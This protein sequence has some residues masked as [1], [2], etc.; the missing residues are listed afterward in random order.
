MHKRR[1]TPAIRLGAC[2]VFD[3]LSSSVVA[4]GAINT[5]E[6]RTRHEG[7]S[8]RIKDRGWIMENS[9]TMMTP[10]DTPPYNSTLS[11]SKN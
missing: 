5:V 8:T 3:M 2:W 7:T 9:D 1:K 10:D 11:S 4:F 6:E